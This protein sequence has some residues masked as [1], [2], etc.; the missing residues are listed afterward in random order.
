MQ[1][2]ESFNILYSGGERDDALTL[3][4][5]IDEFYHT[6]GLEYCEIDLPKLISVV[7]SSYTEFPS[8]YGLE[9]SS[10]FKKVAAFTANFAA[11]KPIATP[12]PSQFGSLSTHQNGVLAVSLAVDA[13]E[14]ATISDPN[15]GDIVL[16][17][18]IKMSRHYWC[19]LVAAA[20]T[21]VPCQHFDY[22]SLIYEALA[23]QFNPD[24]SYAQVI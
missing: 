20:S 5:Y 24:V 18:R 17:N 16:K 12:L 6:L 19:D 9:K 3:C 21:C 1:M 11:E 22:L 2:P 23:Y 10:P 15:R 7:R 4:H 8:P 13:L 14:L